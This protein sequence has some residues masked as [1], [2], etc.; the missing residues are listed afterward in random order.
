MPGIISLQN[1]DSGD[2]ENLF[3]D[4]IYRV[5]NVQGVGGCVIYLKGG[6]S[7]HTPQN[8]DTVATACAHAM[9]N[10]GTIQQI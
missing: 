7:F 2:R 8:E 5:N 1:A 10:P 3:V 4:S 6:E 9:Q